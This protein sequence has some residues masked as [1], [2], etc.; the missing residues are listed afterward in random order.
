RHRPL[1]GP[2]VHDVSASATGHLARGR[3]W[4]AQ[5]MAGR[6]PKEAPARTEGV[7]SRGREI[8]S[9]PHDRRVV[10]LA[11]RG[12]GLARLE[13]RPEDPRRIFGAHAAHL[14]AQLLRRSLTHHDALAPLL[15]A[16]AGVPVAE[17]REGAP[18]SPNLLP[19]AS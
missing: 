15:G 14:R 8:P 9:V 3:L 1:D 12:Y 11:R 5:G 18:G 17:P 6:A 4:R 19:R 10:L 2:D 7:G 16:S 13:A